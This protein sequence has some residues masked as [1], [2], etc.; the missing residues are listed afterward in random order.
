MKTCKQNHIYE[1]NKK[2]CPICASINSRKWKAANRE[3]VKQTQKQ[4]KVRNKEY[5]SNKKKQYEKQRKKTDSLFKL[6]LNVRTLI[7]SQFK[8]FGWSKK[9]KTQQILGCDFETLQSHLIKSAKT[10]Y[11]GKYFP[12]RIYEIDHV[13]PVSTASTED[14]LIKLNHYTNLQFLLKQHNRQKGKRLDFTLA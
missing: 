9:S 12:K 5:E 14:E 4:W 13:V 3:R 11:S 7:S 10:N 2:H 8:S 1:D 6:R